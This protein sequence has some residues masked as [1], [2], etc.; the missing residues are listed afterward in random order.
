MMSVSVWHVGGKVERGETGQNEHTLQRTWEEM[1]DAHF[2]AVTGAGAKLE[3]S[4]H[5]VWMDLFS[6]VLKQAYLY[7]S[8]ILGG[9]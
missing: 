3:P 4:L 2:T 9:F 1:N 5:N 8:P 7:L 6:T